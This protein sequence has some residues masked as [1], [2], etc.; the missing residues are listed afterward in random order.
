[1]LILEPVIT[2]KTIRLADTM[3]QYTFK[4]EKKANKSEASKEI[5]KIYSVKV[6]AVRVHNRLGKPAR[7]G[8]NLRMRTRKSDSKIMIFTLKEG[9]KIEV[10][11][12]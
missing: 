6:E 2:E 4:V 9:D 10:F 8:K 11:T 1:M 3:N 5:G 12:K 7:Y